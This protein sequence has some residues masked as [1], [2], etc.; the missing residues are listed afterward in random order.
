MTTGAI[1]TASM[2]VIQ[3]I[4]NLRPLVLG[5]LGVAAALAVSA[6]L[7]LSA[8]KNP[9]TAYGSLAIGAFGSVDR[10]AVALNKATPYLLTALGVA[11][12][13]RARVI[14]IGGEGQIALGGLAA[15]WVA[16]ELPNAP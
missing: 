9:I 8:G 11:P 12:R 5:A 15:T 13:L 1:D 2:R 14:N 3:S 10:V 7:V 6:L 4:G 16:L